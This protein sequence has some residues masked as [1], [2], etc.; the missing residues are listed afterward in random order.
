MNKLHFLCGKMAAG[1]STLSKQL[2]KEHNAILLS[3]D[4]M[5]GKFYPDEINT[6]QDYVKYSQRLKTVMRPHI[7]ALLKQGSNVVLDFPANTLDQRAWFKDIC[8]VAQVEHILHFVDKSDAVCKEQLKKRNANLP[9]DAP[10][11][12]EATFDA[13]TKYF[14]VPNEQEGFT[15]QVYN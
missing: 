2:A 12:S 13:I 4:E 7:E 5:L 14:Q 11:T 15:I 9:D 1:K 6:L 8:D 3:E 10:L